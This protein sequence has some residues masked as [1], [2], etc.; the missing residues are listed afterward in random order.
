MSVGFPAAALAAAGSNRSGN[1]NAIHPVNTPYP[2]ASSSIPGRALSNEPRAEE[3]PIDAIPSSGR[4]SRHILWMTSKVVSRDRKDA[5]EYLAC[6]VVIW[7]ALGITNAV[8]FFSRDT[9]S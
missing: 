6:R 7:I 1:S 3:L 5:K 2:R 4:A 9:I 8:I